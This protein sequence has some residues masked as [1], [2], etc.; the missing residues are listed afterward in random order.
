MIPADSAKN[1]A[2]V[3]ISNCVFCHATDTYSMGDVLDRI[4]NYF[5]SRGL[6]TE[7]DA[8]ILTRHMLMGV[9][10]CHDTGVVHRDIKLENF[11]VFSDGA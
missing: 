8:S 4:L 10:E 1:S 11:M 3:V 9:K 7:K 5:N 2:D 6:F